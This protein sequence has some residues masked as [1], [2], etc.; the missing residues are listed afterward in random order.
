MSKPLALVVDDDEFLLA[1]IRAALPGFDVEGVANTST[2]I[3]W[4]Q[5]Y[6]PHLVFLDW[7]L[8]GENGEVVLSYIRTEAHLAGVYVVAVSAHP[9]Y[10]PPEGLRIDEILTKPVSLD[11]LR[12]AAART[13]G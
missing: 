2:A 1:I 11:A 13:L 4:L 7:L 5:H 8:P 6:T 10:E 9:D 12:A 3:A